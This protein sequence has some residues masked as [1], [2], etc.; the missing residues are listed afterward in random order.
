MANR[1]ATYTPITGIECEIGGI[2]A[3]EKHT[4]IV[5][6]IMVC[7]HDAPLSKSS[8]TFLQNFAQ[9][10]RKFVDEQF[11]E[12]PNINKENELKGEL[13]IMNNLDDYPDIVLVNDPQQS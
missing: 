1:I 6:T 11:N 9:K 8:A 3:D 2:Q 7:H 10:M 12:Y 13:T 4:A 5:L